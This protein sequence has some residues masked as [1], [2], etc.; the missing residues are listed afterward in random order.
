MDEALTPAGGIRI[1]HFSNHPSHSR[2][3]SS[4]AFCSVCTRS[5]PRFLLR[6]EPRILQHAKMPRGG[7]PRML[8]AASDVPRRRRP[9]PDVQGEQDLPPRR[10]RERRH[11]EGGFSRR[12]RGNRAW[13]SWW[14]K[15]RASLFGAPRIES[16]DEQEP[17]PAKEREAKDPAHWRRAGDP[18]N[19]FPFPILDLMK[20]LQL[21]STTTDREI[22]ERSMSW[23]AGHQDRLEWSIE[24]ETVACDFVYRAARVL[25]EGMM[26]VPARMEDKWVVAWKDGQIA[27]ARSWT[28]ETHVLA[29]ASHQGD[30]I[31]VTALT[32]SPHCM[33]RSFGDPV[34]TFDW[35]MKTHPLNERI[36]LSVSEEGARLLEDVAM[37]SFGPYGHRAFCAARDYVPRASERVLRSDGALLGA[38][39]NADADLVRKLVSEGADMHAPSTVGGYTALHLALVKRDEVLVRTLLDLGADVNHPADENRTPL[40]VGVVHKVSRAILDLLIGAGARMEDADHKKFGVLHAAAEVGNTDAIEYMAANGA[41]VHARTNRGLTPMHIACALGHLETAKALRA[42]GADVHAPSELGTPLDAARGESKPE[43]VAWIE[44]L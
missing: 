19:P 25:P 31:R 7:R 37:A 36:P 6:D 29:R 38:V 14:S 33:L 1:V 5:R 44:S 30:T 12:F 22:A 11:R 40:L 4:R 43:V 9:T 35:L 42:L 20:N 24:G 8:E 16:A 27:V 39:Q 34:I 3:R 26:F 21:T 23:R 17:E 10:M 28:G 2:T 41:S 15:M 32:L 13:M 18:G